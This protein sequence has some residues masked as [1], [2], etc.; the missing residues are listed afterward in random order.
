[1]LNWKIIHIFCYFI[2]T[3]IFKK[4]SK[5]ICSMCEDGTLLMY[6]NLIHPR[7]IWHPQKWNENSP[8]SFLLPWD[9][10]RT[11]LTRCTISQTHVVLNCWYGPFRKNPAFC[12]PFHLDVWEF[13]REK[14]SEKFVK[15]KRWT[16]MTQKWNDMPQSAVDEK[17]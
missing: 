17:K 8:G 4:F 3:Y 9:E 7:K 1:M 11:N 12:D 2:L 5:Q 16:R 14:K 10:F 15:K 13:K 6:S